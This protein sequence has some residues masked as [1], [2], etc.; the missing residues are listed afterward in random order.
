MLS[1]ACVPKR[2][3]TRLRCFD[4][5]SSC[6]Y[7]QYRILRQ[8]NVT[9]FGNLQFYPVLVCLFHNQ[10]LSRAAY[11]YS[12]GREYQAFVYQLWPR[13]VPLSRNVFAGNRWRV[14]RLPAR[15]SASPVI[16]R[17]PA[18]HS[19]YKVKSIV[20]LSTNL[21]TLYPWSVIGGRERRTYGIKG[22]TQNR[23]IELLYLLSIR[24]QTMHIRQ[25]RKRRETEEFSAC[26]DVN[27]VVCCVHYGILRLSISS[28]GRYWWKTYVPWGTG[29]NDLEQ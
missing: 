28:N 4:A 7:A 12:G 21:W 9:P 3:K 6:L 24:C 26:S 10:G 23:N 29:L 11:G 2:M 25:I 13:G 16:L 8:N 5:L 15:T 1:P 14:A 19:A 18:N 22:C 20:E 17:P 27:D